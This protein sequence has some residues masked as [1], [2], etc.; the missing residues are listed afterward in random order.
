MERMVNQNIF[1]D[2]AQGTAL[3]RDDVCSQNRIPA[4]EQP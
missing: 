4:D 2:I 1:D 3:L